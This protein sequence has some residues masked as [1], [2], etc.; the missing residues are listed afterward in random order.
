LIATL[1][2]V[3]VLAVSMPLGHATNN[4][5]TFYTNTA[6]IGTCGTLCKG[7]STT[8]GT[9]STS[10]SQS[11]VIGSSPALDTNSAAEKTGT[12]NSGSS[13]S[14]SSWA[15]TGTADT[16]YLWIVVTG[17]DATTH[18]TATGVTWDVSTRLDTASADGTNRIV[19]W[20][21]HTI[22]AISSETVTVNLSTT[23]TVGSAEIIAFTGS[24]DPAATFT[25]FDQALGFPNSASKTTGA[26]TTP[27]SVTSST[28]LNA[29]DMFVV[30]YASSISA[31]QTVGAG[32]TLDLTV[33]SLSSLAIEH[34]SVTS[35]TVQTC[36][37]GTGENRWYVAC[38]ALQSAP[39]YYKVEPESGSTTLT[40]TPL[41]SANGFSGT[42]WVWNTVGLDASGLV[43]DIQSG[44]WQI[45]ATVTTGSTTGTPVARIWVEAWS[46][47]T[48]SCTTTTLLWKNWDTATNVATCT[49]ACSK[50]TYTA[51]GQPSFA[52]WT[53]NFLVFEVWAVLQY[54]G[55]TTSTT[56]TETTGS[57]AMDFIT[58]GWDYALGL[59]GSLGLASS[60]FRTR[61][62]NLIASIGSST[63][64]AEKASFFRSLSG[65][66][67]EVP[68]E[69][70]GF[71][72]SL[73][74]SL[75]SSSVFGEKTSLLR[76][77]SDSLGFVSS[78]FIG[79]TVNLSAQVGPTSFLA[80]KNS[81]FRSLSDSL[82]LAVSETKGFLRG[83]SSS[84]ASSSG[85]ADKSSLFRSLTASLTMGSGFVDRSS[86]LRSLTGS[87]G[88]SSGLVERSSLYKSLTDSLSL[89]SGFAQRT[90]F[91]RSLSGSLSPASSI[92]EKSSLFRAMIASFAL[93]SSETR[94][95]LKS[96]TGSLGPASSFAEQSF[97]FR[98]LSDS[99]GFVS[100]LF[101][102]RTV[103]LSASIGSSSSPVEKSSWFRSFSGSIAV[104]SSLVDKISLFRSLNSSL[105]SASAFVE[106]T[107]LFRSLSASIFSVSSF[108]ERSSLLRFLTGSLGSASSF[109]DKNSIFRSLSGSWTTT[110]GFAEKTSFFKSL[111]GSIGA[112]SSFAKKISLFRS[113]TGFLGPA[114]SETKSLERVLTSSLGSSTS[115]AQNTSFIRSLSGS[116]SQVTSETKGFTR[117]FTDSLGFGA[118]EAKG[119]AEG[120]S[121]SLGSSSSFAENSSLFRFLSGSLSLV[122]SGYRGS[123][124][125]E[126]LHGKFSTTT[127]LSGHSDCFENLILNCGSVSASFAFLV[128]ALGVLIFSIYA[129]KQ[130][131]QSLAHPG[132]L[133]PE[134]SLVEKEGSETKGFD[135]DK[136]G[137]ETRD[138]ADEEG[139]E[140]KA[141]D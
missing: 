99:L 17:A 131:R 8:S 84:L 132:G 79:R 83:F 7:L 129:T 124:F 114:S 23:P 36:A 49:S 10:T 48:N 135:D 67:S 35:T 53:G 42:G 3:I 118:S 19:L 55:S 81:L 13:I 45:D 27:P 66:L 116:L 38:D 59:S 113:L 121:G 133:K 26:G 85:I 94:G 106:R 75:G 50:T 5:H 70:K 12:W 16:V 1:I 102:G 41:T 65:S 88:S 2:L 52:S 141:E 58:P 105:T 61:V 137:R 47:T 130:R 96:L 57:T 97:L 46:C 28:N 31:S 80:E 62:A 104:A 117:S 60:S 103:N 74:A 127:V 39:K 120:L 123:L 64:V 101:S 68:S 82:S 128:I 54:S 37:F 98:S 107:S 56:L 136:E 77:L 92:A 4:V 112:A 21:G 51:T 63:S 108:N 9:A 30:F 78:R 6:T 69:T 15:T 73:S 14:I 44:T 20:V 87:L 90:S 126:N 86:L 122:S 29:D 89:I 110:S 95:Y 134:E 140:T 91:S 71:I 93:V 139:W 109:A 111:S 40:G 22:A 33:A 18:P 119:F 32:F 34:K 100:S 115:L 11:V 25:P 72:R 138:I 24:E 76:S 125:T 43:N